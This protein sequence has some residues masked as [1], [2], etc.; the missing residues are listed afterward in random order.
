MSSFIATQNC[1]KFFSNANK[2]VAG[3]SFQFKMCFLGFFIQYQLM[4]KRCESALLLCG[5]IIRSR[6]FS[7]KN[8]SRDWAE[9]ELKRQKLL[10]KSWQTCNENICFGKKTE[11]PANQ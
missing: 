9:Y 11:K 6:D 5:K 7:S 4:D 8:W 10:P 1:D 2:A 3:L